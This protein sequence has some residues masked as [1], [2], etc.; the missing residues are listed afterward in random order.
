MVCFNAFSQAEIYKSDF[1][2]DDFNLDQLSGF[3][4]NS[5]DNILFTA[6]D[7]K[8]YS[9]D[10][11]EKER[12]WEIYADSDTNSTLYLYHNT[13]F[14]SNYK[15]GVLKT[16]QY[17]LSTGEKI[18]ELSIETI[19]TKPYFLNNIMYCTVLADGGKLAAYDLDENKIV[20]KKNIGHGIEVEPVYLKDK[21]T[22]NAEDDNWF[23]IDYNGNFL[24]TKSKRHIYLD[25][26]EIFVK[27]YKFLTHDNKEIDQDFLKKNK[28]NNAEYQIRTTEANTFLWSENQLLILGNNKKKILQLDL[29]KILS[30]TNFDSS[31]YNTILEINPQSVWFCY[32]S[33]LIHYD[34]RNKKILREVDLTQWNPHQIVL[35]DKTIWLISKNDGQLYALD[36]ERDYKTSQMIKA[37]ADYYKCTPPDPKKA[38][39]AKA[40][41]KEYNKNFK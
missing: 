20:W 1:V 16:T 32:Q 21:I 17:N 29:E 15:N 40:A 41:Q 7:H 14:C 33:Y 34:F 19:N 23:E 28:L 39:A 31:A 11:K 3:I 10:K 6:S 2:F 22:A 18:K 30:V 9:I 26:T 8:V 5:G 4:I 13:F 24:K 38:E 25:T 37:K 36:F 27:N 12:N 35:E